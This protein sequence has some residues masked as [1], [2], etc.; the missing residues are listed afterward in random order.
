[1]YDGL[2]EYDDLNIHSTVEHFRMGGRHA[3]FGFYRQLVKPLKQGRK[4][5]GIVCVCVKA[6]EGTNYDQWTWLKCVRVFTNNTNNLLSHVEKKHTDV[7]SVM[8]LVSKK[9]K[10]GSVGGKPI[11]VSPRVLTRVTS[12]IAATMK[13]VSVELVKQDVFRW[14]IASGTPFAK[15]LAPSFRRI[16]ATQISGISGYNGLESVFSTAGVNM[17]TRQTNMRP[18]RYAKKAIMHHNNKFAEKHVYTISD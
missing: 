16:F 4:K 8:E 1:V 15:T 3:V 10:N 7:V 13:K 5:L 12:S 17:S 14:P 2:V 6:L 9:K 11:I 18:E